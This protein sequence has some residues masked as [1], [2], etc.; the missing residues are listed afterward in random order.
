MANIT[1]RGNSYLIR[2]SAGY[3]I[4][5][6][7]IVKS[8]TWKIPN[9]MTAKKAEK[10]ALHQASLFEEQVRNESVLDTNIRLSDFIERWLSDYAEFHLK[11]RTIASYLDYSKK[12]N[13]S[14]GHIKMAQIKPTTI[15]KFYKELQK[16]IVNLYYILKD[17]LRTIL[18]SKN[19]TQVAFMKDNNITK[20]VL[21]KALNNE[22]LT[23]EQAKLIAEPLGFTLKDD[24]HVVQEEKKL[25]SKTIQNYHRFLS[26]V[27]STAVHWQII[28]T[29][30]AER[31]S[32]PKAIR[33]EALTLNI[34]DT[35]TL[36]KCL[37][38]EPALFNAA[39]T[40]LLYS[41]MRRGECLGLTWD[42]IDFDNRKISINKSVLYLPSVGVFVDTPKT[43]GSIRT[44]E[45]PEIT[46]EKL[47][48]WR[49]EQTKQKITSKEVW[50]DENW[51]FTRWDG[52]VIRPDY[53]TSWFHDFIK[54]HNLPPIHLHSLRHT[55]ASLL[56][57]SGTSLPTVAHRLGHANPSTTSS[58]YSHLIDE[59]DSIASKSMEALLKNP[60]HSK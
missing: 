40:T 23:K 54:K 44:I 28:P 32:P 15:L 7:Q 37:E 50:K 48:L 18:K 36:L 52:T 56:L 5:G 25:S 20:W 4:N 58:I 14:I 60:N 46:I 10:E 16:P 22:T 1:K 6:K 17:D 21:L 41:G 31:V 26:S 57:A 53:L 47:L 43:P 11:A 9:G 39:I 30:P 12:V 33:S 34:N 49:N 13:E 35:L 29:N 45:V 24:F 8:M 2:C 19:I 59:S 42:D 27:L 51:I 38:S 3:D 55:N